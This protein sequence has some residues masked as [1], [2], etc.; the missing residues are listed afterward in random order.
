MFER[1]KPHVVEQGT[2]SATV[3]LTDGVCVSGKMT[4]PMGR[5]I[6]DALNGPSTFLEFEP[7]GEEKVLIAKASIIKVQSIQLP[8][9]VSLSH[10]AREFD[11]FD[12]HTVL[13][14]ERSATWD[15]VRQAYIGLAKDYH[16]DRYSNIELPAEV[17]AYLAAMARRVNVAYTALESAH[18]TKK[19][20]TALRQAPIYTSPSMRG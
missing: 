10:R 3:T 2:L 16:P 8:G 6:M 20:I 7:F 11:G 19:E 12:P 14:V 15:D 9:V 13:G 1:N 17:T 4:V 5:C 18:Q